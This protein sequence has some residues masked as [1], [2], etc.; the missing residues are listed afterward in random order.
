MSR[1]VIGAIDQRFQ[2]AADPPLRALDRVAHIGIV[3]GT[4]ITTRS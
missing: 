1:G 2:R 4:A 3:T